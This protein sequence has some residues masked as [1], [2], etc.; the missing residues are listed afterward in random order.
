[1]TTVSGV[2]TVYYR[3]CL[4][5]IKICKSF[6]AGVGDKSGKRADIEV[7]VTLVPALLLSL[8]ISVSLT[9]GY[10]NSSI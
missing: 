3:N 9:Y 8:I 2:L 4:E 5:E 1:M 10:E 7:R 6:V